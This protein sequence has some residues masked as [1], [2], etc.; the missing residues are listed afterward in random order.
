MQLITQIKA[1]DGNIKTNKTVD[2]AF[3]PVTPT[4]SCAGIDDGTLLKCNIP[5]VF[6]SNPEQYIVKG[7]N[8]TNEPRFLHF[9]SST[10]S[11]VAEGTNWYRDVVKTEGIKVLITHPES[12]NNCCDVYIAFDDTEFNLIPGLI[13]KSSITVYVASNVTASSI[14]GYRK[15]SY[16]TTEGE[17]S[18]IL[19]PVCITPYPMGD[20]RVFFLSVYKPADSSGTVRVHFTWWRQKQAIERGSGT[21]LVTTKITLQGQNTPESP[22]IDV[23][24]TQLENQVAEL[25]TQI[26]TELKVI[27]KRL[28]DVNKS[29]SQVS[30]VFVSR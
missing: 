26:D 8:N 30:G 1:K 20:D 28:E 12:S 18:V 6:Y 11:W 29:L 15:W 16:S 9:D 10:N 3:S 22:T 27:S 24:L 19:A 25:T 2:F 23:R 17:D 14:N 4:I 21:V 5:N 13:D 7:Q